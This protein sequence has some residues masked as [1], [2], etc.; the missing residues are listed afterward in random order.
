MPSP[1]RFALIK[2]LLE[3]QGWTY[4][5]GKGSHNV[6]SRPGYTPIVIPVHANKVQP[7]YV[8]QVERAIQLVKECE[9]TQGHRDGQSEATQGQ[10]DGQAK[11]SKDGSR[12]NRP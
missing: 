10:S 8:R 3:S 12:N 4:R 6:F 7:V 9:A 5:A 1:V 2:Q 11:D